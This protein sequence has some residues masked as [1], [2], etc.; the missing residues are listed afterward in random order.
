MGARRPGS[1]QGGV[2]TGY[3]VLQGSLD[4]AENHTRYLLPLPHLP[5]FLALW[6]SAFCS[7]LNTNTSGYLD[8]RDLNKDGAVTFV[9][10]SQSTYGHHLT[11]VLPHPPCSVSV[12]G[13]HAEAVQLCVQKPCALMRGPYGMPIRAVNA[14]ELERLK[15]RFMKLDRCGATYTHPAGQVVLTLLATLK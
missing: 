8:I 13:G 9:A 15:K 5:R 3:T 4:G 2:P 7:R 11:E 12:Y 14:S 1:F 6:T 10:P